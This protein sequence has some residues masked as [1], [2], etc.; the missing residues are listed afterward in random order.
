MNFTSFVIHG[1]EFS[2]LILYILYQQKTF[3][4]K[5]NI[6]L[7]GTSKREK[8]NYKLNTLVKP[9]IKYVTA[10]VRSVILQS[11]I[12]NLG[13]LYWLYVQTHTPSNTVHLL[14]KLL[15]E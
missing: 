12:G 9:D 1:F 5:N 13:R 4:L 14:N 8:I 10:Y 15:D 2:F 7:N 6:K 11:T 3:V